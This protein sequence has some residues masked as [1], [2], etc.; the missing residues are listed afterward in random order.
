MTTRRV[1]V[2]LLATIA[3]LVSSALS[4]RA[5]QEN[6]AETECIKGTV[7]KVAEKALYLKDTSF[8]DETLG[9]RDATVLLDKATTYYDG[10]KKVNKADLQP[11][12]IVLVRCRMAGKDRAAVLVRIIGGK[13][14]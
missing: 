11:G 8:P 13:R 14:L 5:Q 2:C 1:F 6:A 10:P 12:H 9:K 4:T 3:L 7:V